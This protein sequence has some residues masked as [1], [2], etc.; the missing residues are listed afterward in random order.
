MPTE[1]LFATGAQAAAD[2]AA[3]IAGILSD[4]I[5]ARGVA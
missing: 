4:A 5:A 3:R 2:I 1:H